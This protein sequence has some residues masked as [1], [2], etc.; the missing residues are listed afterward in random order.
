MAVT[1]SLR[2]F[3]LHTR[4]VASICQLC[5]VDL[6]CNLD[7]N[8]TDVAIEFT[9]CDPVAQVCINLNDLRDIDCRC[10]NGEDCQSGR[11]EGIFGATTCQAKLED[12]QGCNEDSD[13]VSGHCNFRFIC[14][15]KKAEELT[16]APTPV[17]LT[18]APIAAEPTNAPIAQLGT[19]SS[20]DQTTSNGIGNDDDGS[21]VSLIVGLIVGAILFLILCC[22]LGGPKNC[23]ANFVLELLDSILEL[24]G[25]CCSCLCSCFCELCEF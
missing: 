8:T 25:A 7:N 17:E 5:L 13:C 22:L 1:I 14:V 2:V 10:S 19:P 3:A 15:S 23:F 21:N 4:P 12:E 11:C 6:D 20:T 18:S 16:S 24:L 9:I